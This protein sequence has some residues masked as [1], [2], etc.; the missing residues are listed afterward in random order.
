MP[1]RQTSL[2]ACRVPCSLR[3]ATVWRSVNRHFI[4]GRS[5]RGAWPQ[6]LRTSRWRQFPGHP[7]TIVK[8]TN[9]RPHLLS[10]SSGREALANATYVNYTDIMSKWGTFADRVGVEFGEI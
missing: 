6:K 8:G 5:P 4:T 10:G 2:V 9:R 7:V 1:C 3:T